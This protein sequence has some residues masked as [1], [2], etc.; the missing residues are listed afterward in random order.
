MRV[1][2]EGRKSTFSFCP[3]CGA[4]VHYVMEGHEESIAIPVGAF[5]EPG[6]PAPTF[7]VYEERK[8]SWVAMPE[9]IEHVA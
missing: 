1:G 2:D 4:T 7:S 5:A 6:F 8:H 9:N 3:N